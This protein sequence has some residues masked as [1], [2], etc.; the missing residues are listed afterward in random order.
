MNK[1]HNPEESVLVRVP[2]K[3]AF[4]HRILGTNCGR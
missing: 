4:W 2:A 1:G 3:I